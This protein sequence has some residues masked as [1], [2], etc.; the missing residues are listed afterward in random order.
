MCLYYVVP[1][2]LQ[3]FRSAGCLGLSHWGNCCFNYGV[4]G[5]YLV[6]QL[7][8]V[9]GH[10]STTC[11][12][13]RFNCLLQGSK[14]EA[15]PCSGSSAIRCGHV[16]LLLLHVFIMQSILF[17]LTQLL[18]E[19]C[20]T[21]GLATTTA[22]PLLYLLF[23]NAAVQLAAVVGLVTALSGNIC[24]LSVVSQLGGRRH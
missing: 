14:S 15:A 18:S 11:H 9:V 1:A 23:G 3:V 13:M 12:I 2:C 17:V 21:G 24:P 19:G 6:S 5:H 22:L 4:I 8:L 7:P 20:S 10:M 16:L